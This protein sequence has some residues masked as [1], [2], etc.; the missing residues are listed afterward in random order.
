[1]DVNGQ[2]GRLFVVSLKLSASFGPIMIEMC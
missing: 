1:M 2:P